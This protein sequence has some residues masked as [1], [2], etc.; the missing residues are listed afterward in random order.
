VATKQQ[1]L[2][3]IGRLVSDASGTI[4]D[5]ATASYHLQNAYTEAQRFINIVSPA[6][7][8]D[9]VKANVIAGQANYQ[10]PSF[11]AIRRY[12]WLRV[13]SS[14]AVYDELRPLVSEQAV[15]EATGRQSSVEAGLVTGPRYYI[16]GQEIIIVPTPTQSVTGGLGAIVVEVALLSSPTD[17]PRMPQSLHRL[18]AYGAAVMALEETKDAAEAVVDRYR[19]LWESVFSEERFRKVLSG[20]YPRRQGL[21]FIGRN[22]ASA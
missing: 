13:G 19:R 15:G 21:P 22:L 11:E 14:P 7:F 12:E 10:R 8:E 4:V 6:E 9:P 17:L 16:Q 20:Y 2:D 18:L 3:Q 5:P 1:L